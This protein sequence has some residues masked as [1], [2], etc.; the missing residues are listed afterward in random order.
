[1]NKTKQ[2]AAYSGIYTQEMEKLSYRKSQSVD[3]IKTIEHIGEV[4]MK[5]LKILMSP[6]CV[7]TDRRVPDH[8][9]N[10]C[11]PDSKHKGQ[12]AITHPR[13][14]ACRCQH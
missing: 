5:H 1:M 14:L 4:H 7:H 10:I 2:A 9:N 12:M 3:P 13:P 11:L 6:Q 8:R